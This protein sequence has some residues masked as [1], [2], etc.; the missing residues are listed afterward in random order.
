MKI[1]HEV[2]EQKLR[3]GY[4]T[5][6]GLVRFCVGRAE[7]VARRP[8]NE[9]LE[10]SA[11]DGAFLSALT[12]VPERH[13]T[14][15]ELN[16]EEAAKCR[17]R[18]S[19]HGKGCVVRGSFF[20][21]IASNPNLAFDAVVGNPPYVR[22]QFL[23]LE[24]RSA[25]S[26]LIDALGLKIQGVSN[27]WILFALVAM[28]RIR[29]G[30]SFSMVLPSELFSTISAGQCRQELIAEYEDVQIDMFSRDVFADLLQDV[31]VVS[32]RR[33]SKRL[34]KRTVR[35]VE[36]RNAGVSS[37]RWPVQASHDA[38]MKHLLTTDESQ[39]FEKAL[40]LPSVRKLGDI[41]R[42]QVSIVTGAN[43]YFT[44]P[45]DVVNTYNL[46]PWTIA[47]L[48]KTSHSPGLRYT[49][50][51]FVSTRTS[52]ARA[53]L[54]DFGSAKPKPHGKARKY[55]A[56]GEAEG[57]PERYKC[58]TRTPWYRVPHIEFGSLML[59]KRAHYHH[60]LIEN[61]ASVA[62]TDTV[63]R[64]KPINGYS[65]SD[66]VAGFHN[67]FTLLSAELE[68]R[69]YGG[70]VLELVPSEI[71]RL[72]VPMIHGLGEQLDKLD[73]LS[74]SSGGQ[75]DEDDQLADATDA[76]L[77]TKVPGLGPLLDDLRGAR[78]RLRMRRFQGV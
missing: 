14:C 62:T 39:S 49:K 47:L 64:G 74:R 41:A 33:A 8:L 21:W 58:R 72:S 66:I 19:E 2:S 60:R 76:I 5:P 20:P 1:R 31:V 77:A 12:S 75:R 78:T 6:E 70:G 13:L 10:P 16:P 26:S 42:I 15:I 7:Q 32:G 51:D 53:W 17:L 69:T 55:L 37:W 59:T 67:S 71:R 73:A 48:P 63:Y 68:G 9:W 44:V 28:R 22:Y 57:I 36:H 38:W 61:A 43:S 24:D 27:A 11:G 29:P 23:S 56:I 35:F 46:H 18:M 65:G 50:D 34:T 25:A 54:L 52:G 40:S 30:G 4:Y 3:G 45:D